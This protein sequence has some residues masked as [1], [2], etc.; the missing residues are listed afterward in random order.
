[1]IFSNENPRPLHT[2]W[3]LNAALARTHS[4]NNKARHVL[5]KLT[6]KTSR[7][8]QRA[9]QRILDQFSAASDIQ[10][11]H[12]CVLVEGNRAR[13]HVKNKRDFLHRVAFSEKLQDFLLPQGE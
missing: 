11:L 9:S 6:G 2:V 4:T 1:M 5:A 8:S 10:M 7:K 13:R 3:L 12:H